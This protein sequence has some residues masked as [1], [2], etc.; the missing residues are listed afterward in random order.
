M[1]IKEASVQGIKHEVL[2]FLDKLVEAQETSNSHLF[3]LCF[4]QND[5][6]VNIGTD[7]DE[8]WVGWKSF[9]NYMQEIIESRHDYKIYTRDTKIRFS[10]DKNIAWYSQ[11]MDT[12]METKGDPFRIEGFRHT[13]VLKKTTNGWKIVQSHVSIPYD[14]KKEK[15]TPES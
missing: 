15:D 11:L 2:M 14:Y 13:G 6:L 5:S 9:F 8:Y 3:A 7:L 4:M 12:C 10:D 1:A